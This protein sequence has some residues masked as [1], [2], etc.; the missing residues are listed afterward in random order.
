[1][2]II[3]VSCLFSVNFYDM[4]SNWVHLVTWPLYIFNFFYIAS[5]TMSGE[6]RGRTKPQRMDTEPI[7]DL[8]YIDSKKKNCRLSD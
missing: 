6:Y 4:Y 8:D 2:K 5:K 3:F 7:E 1:M